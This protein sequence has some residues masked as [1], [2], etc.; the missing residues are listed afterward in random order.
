[1][2]WPI[3]LPDVSAGVIA[4][5][6]ASAVHGGD[7]FALLTVAPPTSGGQA[8][9]RDL[10][11]LID[12][13]GSMGGR[14]LD[15]ASQVVSAMIETLGPNDRIELIEFGSSPKH[16]ARAPLAAT[17]K[18]KKAAIKWMRNLRASGCTEMHR[19]VLEALAPLRDDSQRQVILVTDGYIGFEQ[20]IVATL[21]RELPDGARLHTIGVGSSVNRTLTQ[22]AAR[23]G[24]GTELIIGLDEDP[25]GLVARL[26]AKTTAPLVTDIVVSGPGV[27]EVAPRQLP[28]LYAESP[29]L[30]AAR[31]KPEGGT[32][33][34]SGRTAAGRFEQRLEVPALA[35]GEGHQGVVA[36]FGREKVEDLEMNLSAGGGVAELNSAIEATGIDF[37]ISTRLTSWVAVSK[38]ATVASRERPETVEQ[39]HELPH[40]VS[41]EGL[42]LRKPQQQAGIGG[43]GSRPA[44][45]PSRRSAAKMP[46]RLRSKRRASDARGKAGRA[47][48]APQKPQEKEKQESAPAQDETP[49]P[50]TPTVEV[51]SIADD[52]GLVKTD[53][54]LVEVGSDDSMELEASELMDDLIGGDDEASIDYDPYSEL[55]RLEQAPP[56][57]LS[58]TGCGAFVVS[59]SNPL[60]ADMVKWTRE[61]GTRARAAPRQGSVGRARRW[62]LVVILFMILALIAAWIL[63]AFDGAPSAPTKPSATPMQSSTSPGVGG[64]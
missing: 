52:M 40:G 4:A 6:P 18:N 17:A 8:V 14:P 3:S 61:A 63:G 9:A 34:V 33:V 21:L 58:L 2:R 30:F 54:D 13:S 32:V 51:P 38:T 36:L 49:E 42:G 44:H 37:Q 15:L 43:R 10:T 50:R 23:A 5:R 25:Q 16:F 59:P 53:S 26:L 27:I 46:P 48:P 47:T 57:S 28:D 39:P 11:F 24:R 22:G 64:K 56:G 12:T 45:A 7:T 55:G 1:M 31:L 20:E 19:A 29:A 60:P 35:V 62:S 41:A